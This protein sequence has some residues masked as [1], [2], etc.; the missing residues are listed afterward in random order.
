MSASLLDSAETI[1]VIL[2]EVANVREGSYGRRI[3][4][5]AA[6]PSLLDQE[7]LPLRES[8]LASVFA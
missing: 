8:A 2:I 4:A 6:E 1:D 5:A 7:I 3:Y